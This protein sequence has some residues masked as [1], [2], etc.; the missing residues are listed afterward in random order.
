MAETGEVLRRDLVGDLSHNRW[1]QQPPDGGDLVQLL[2]VDHRHPE[3]LVRD[4]DDQVL[5]GEVEHRL[6]YGV[7]ETPNVAA[8]DGAE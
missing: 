8:S 4:D 6:A 5:L 2:L 3:A 1:L 7:A